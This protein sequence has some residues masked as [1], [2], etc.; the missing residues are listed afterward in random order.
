MC[1]ELQNYPGYGTECGVGT[2]TLIDPCLEPEDVTVGVPSNCGSDYV[3]AAT[4]LF[5]VT[6][7]MPPM[8]YSY[9]VYTCSFIGGPQ[10]YTGNYDLCGGIYQNGNFYTQITFDT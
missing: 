7:I 10:G 9:A 3:D 4:C 1:A 5:P 2:I 6:Q 8:C